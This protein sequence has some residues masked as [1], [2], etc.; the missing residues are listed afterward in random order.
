MANVHFMRKLAKDELWDTLFFASG[1]VPTSIKTKDFYDLK[2]SKFQAKIYNGNRI[3]VNGTK[4]HGTRAAK[5][6]IQ[7]NI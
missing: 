6:F 7:E 1:E 5:M 3:V 4:C 2:T